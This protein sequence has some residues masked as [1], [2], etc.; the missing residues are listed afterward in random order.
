M[1]CTDSIREFM[2][3]K[4]FFNLVN[5]VLNQ[6][7]PKG[8]FNASPGKGYSIHEVYCEIANY[9]NYSKTEVPIVPV[10][11]DDKEL[12]LDPTKTENFGWKT[13]VNFK[14]TIHNQLKWYDLFGVNDIYSHL[15]GPEL[16]L[17]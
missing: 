11:E 13:K 9:L 6:D 3:I 14:E 16:K 7:T 15:K 5:I 12:V 8:I 10:G 1:F 17:E 2:D 4:D